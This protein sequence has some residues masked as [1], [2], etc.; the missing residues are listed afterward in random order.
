MAHRLL[1]MFDHWMC[2]YTTWNENMLRGIVPQ[3]HHESVSD[4]KLQ[5][6]LLKAIKMVE[7]EGGHPDIIWTQGEIR[8]LILTRTIPHHY[9]I[10]QV[11]QRDR[12]N[13]DSI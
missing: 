3:C 5:C 4:W 1:A 6:I 13:H 8:K 9:T 7:I 2:H 12:P 11:G 10:T